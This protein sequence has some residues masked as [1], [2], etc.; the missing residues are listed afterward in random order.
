[1]RRKGVHH[2]TLWYPPLSSIVT[3]LPVS[4]ATI[5][6]DAEWVLDGFIGQVLTIVSDGSNWWILSNEEIN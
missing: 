6:S 1:M 5:E 3:L 2:Q 4:G